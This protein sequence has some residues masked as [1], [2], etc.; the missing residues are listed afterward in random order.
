MGSELKICKQSAC[1]KCSVS[2]TEHISEQH[3]VAAEKNR[4]KVSTFIQLNPKPPSSFRSAATVAQF[5]I[6]LHFLTKL[7]EQGVGHAFLFPQESLKKVRE[8][9]DG[10]VALMSTRPL[11]DWIASHKASYSPASKGSLV[12]KRLSLYCLREMPNFSKM[13]TMNL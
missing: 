7:L 9:F 11:A 5:T 6:M 12:R 3:K 10:G 2:K 8:K 13:R 1:S 4:I